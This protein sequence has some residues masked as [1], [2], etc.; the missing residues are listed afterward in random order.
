MKLEEPTPL[1]R[2]QDLP[3]LLSDEAPGEEEKCENCGDNKNKPVNMKKK[4]KECGCRKCGGKEE[5]NNQVF[6][7]ENL[8]NIVRGTT[9]PGY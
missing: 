3:P 7:S 9:D 4:C 2:E 1:P 6:D 8:K 5:P